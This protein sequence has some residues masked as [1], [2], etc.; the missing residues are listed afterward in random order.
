METKSDDDC[1]RDVMEIR[2]LI[3]DS[4]LTGLS[5]SETFKAEGDGTGPEKSKEV[6]E[7]KSEREE[8]SKME[9]IGERGREGGRE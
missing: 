8:L 2:S 9:G 6:T 3:E 1:S 7:I 4:E 5:K